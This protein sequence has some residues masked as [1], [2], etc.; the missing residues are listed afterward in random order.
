M[1]ERE[2]GVMRGGGGVGEQV[3]RGGDEAE[4]GRANTLGRCSGFM[5]LT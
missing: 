3:G 1:G 2:G 4:R 5:P